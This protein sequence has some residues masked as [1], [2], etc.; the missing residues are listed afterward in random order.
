MSPP[1]LV[2][3]SLHLGNDA[4]CEHNIGGGKE[5]LGLHQANTFPTILHH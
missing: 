2:N 3:P 4:R 5:D 1:I